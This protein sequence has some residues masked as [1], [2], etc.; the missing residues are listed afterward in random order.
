MLQQ[1]AK[2]MR[3]NWKLCKIGEIANETVTQFHTKLKVDATEFS[4]RKLIPC[5][6]Y[7]EIRASK[8]CYRE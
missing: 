5:S 8:P 1:L 4:A 6:K 3:G 2:L 7:W